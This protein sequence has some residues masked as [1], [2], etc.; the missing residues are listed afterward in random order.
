VGAGSV[1]LWAPEEL[2]DGCTGEGESSDREPVSMERDSA[3]G[4]IRFSRLGSRLGK[5]EPHLAPS[6]RIRATRDPASDKALVSRFAG[7]GVLPRGASWPLWDNGPLCRRWIEWCEE[8]IAGGL[9]S[10]KL[11]REQIARHEAQIRDNPKPID[12]L[13][14]IRLQDVAP[15]ASLLGL[16]ERGTLLF[17]YD[18]E[19]NMGSFWPEARAGWDILYAENEDEPVLVEE[20][21]L[22]RSEFA[23]C[24][25]SFE[26]EYALPEDLREE[27]GDADLRCYGNDEYARIYNALRGIGDK[28]PV[29]HQLGGPPVEV[30]NGLF[31]QCQLTSNG[32]RGGSPEALKRQQKR[33][34]ELEPGVKDWR[35]LLQIDSDE[36][37]P[38]WMWGDVG[39]LYFCLRRDDLAARRF[40]R[41]WCAEQCG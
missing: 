25:L 32:V 21:R 18:V 15:H 13:A 35:L 17:F 19:R 23:P 33:V 37:G 22:R 12:F 7:H 26:L 41:S 40:D 5:I 36:A 31:R 28:D 10:A 4:L 24:A 2:G 27:T 29:I 1:S 39:R 38:G 11:M 16:P 20:P 34:K 6:L 9:G 14:M 8:R 3:I 30:Q